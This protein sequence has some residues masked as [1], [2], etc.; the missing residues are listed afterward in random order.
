MKSGQMSILVD[1]VKQGVGA[2]NN[3]NTARRFFK[4]PA[5]SSSVTGVDQ[6]LISRLPKPFLGIQN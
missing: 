5:L 2:T 4:N 6:T 1:V 3:G